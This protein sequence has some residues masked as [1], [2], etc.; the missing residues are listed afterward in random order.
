MKYHNRILVVDDEKPIRGV[1]GMMCKSEG[2]EA[3]LAE[4]GLEAL[5]KIDDLSKKNLSY[6]IIC[7][8]LHMEPIDGLELIKGIFTR[9]HDKIILSPGIVIFTGYTPPKKEIFGDERDIRIDIYHKPMGI[10]L[11]TALK[12]RYEEIRAQ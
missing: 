6:P 8:D 9:T 1:L 10:E 3:D 11:V 7:T 12:K 2:L 5:S 4:D